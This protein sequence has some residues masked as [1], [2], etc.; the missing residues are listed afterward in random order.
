MHALSSGLPKLFQVEDVKIAA[1]L[2]NRTLTS[3]LNFDVSESVWS[4]IPANCSHLKVFDCATYAHQ[5]I[6]KL[7][8]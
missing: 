8:P 1:Y 4:K 7:E 2:V 6:G 5:S 3:A